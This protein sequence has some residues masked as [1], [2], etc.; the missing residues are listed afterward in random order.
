MP[1]HRCDPNNWESFKADVARILLKV[2]LD[3]RGKVVAI[4]PGKIA[5]LCL[6]FEPSTFLVNQIIPATLEL[7][8]SCIVDKSEKEVKYC[9]SGNC[10][11]TKRVTYIVDVACG[12][13]ALTAFLLPRLKSSYFI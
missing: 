8:N 10:R 3:Q 5:K 11:T 6:G 13:E 9:R 2:L 12:I 4:K 1:V 7:L